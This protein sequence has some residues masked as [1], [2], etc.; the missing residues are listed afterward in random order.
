MPHFKVAMETFILKWKLG[1]VW[2]GE[3]KGGK[4]PPWHFSLEILKRMGLTSIQVAYIN[5][6]F[7]L[8]YLRNT[9]L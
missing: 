2:D 5:T 3:K 4:R 6:D 8:V 1:E 7:W 9:Y